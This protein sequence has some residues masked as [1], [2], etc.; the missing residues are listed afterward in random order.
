M[1]NLSEYAQPLADGD[2]QIV[3]YVLARFKN[4]TGR[5]MAHYCVELGIATGK[6]EMPFNPQPITV[7][8]IKTIGGAVF[9]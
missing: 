6:F 8:Q 9:G 2:K 1:P 3:E 7:A 4:V 5:D